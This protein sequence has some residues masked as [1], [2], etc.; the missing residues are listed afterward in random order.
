MLSWWWCRLSQTS[1]GILRVCWP[2][3]HARLLVGVCVPETEALQDESETAEPV[4]ECAGSKARNIFGNESRIIRQSH[5]VVSMRDETAVLRTFNSFV[6]W[7]LTAVGSAVRENC[8]HGALTGTSIAHCDNTESDVLTDRW[9]L[10]LRSHREDYCKCIATP[11]YAKT[12]D[13]L[14]RG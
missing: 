8:S 1:V 11:Q 9:I 10:S 13:H 5:C 3:F 4:G 2:L 6:S 7:H 12:R 14:I